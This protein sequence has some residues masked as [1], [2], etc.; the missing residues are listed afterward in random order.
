MQV[1]LD[2]R[3]PETFDTTPR[4]GFSQGGT[5]ASVISCS[6]TARTVSIFEKYTLYSG[7]WILPDAISLPVRIDGIH[8]YRARFNISRKMGKVKEFGVNIRAKKAQGKKCCK[9]KAE[10]LKKT[11][12]YSVLS[13]LVYTNFTVS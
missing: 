12:I 2:L 4:K 6:G 7:A 11:E 3:G 1:T 5:Y 8:L 10:Q 9:T 13:R